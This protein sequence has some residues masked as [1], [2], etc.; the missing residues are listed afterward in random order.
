MIKCK[1]CNQLSNESSIQYMKRTKKDLNAPFYCRECLRIHSY[2]SNQDIPLVEHVY[3]KNDKVTK[4]VE[5][6]YDMTS[7]SI[8]FLMRKYKIS[9][10]AAKILAENNAAM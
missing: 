7:T 1:H 4:P 10:Q 9:H 8:P 3:V 6:V 2:L 5:P